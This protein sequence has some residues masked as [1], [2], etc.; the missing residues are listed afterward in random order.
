M[1]QEKIMRLSQAAR[2]LNVGTTTIIAHLV[3]K[4][5]EVEHTPHTKITLDQFN[6]L[7]KEFF[8]AAVD[9]KEASGIT[10]G[11]SYENTLTENEAP[12]LALREEEVTPKHETT[13]PQL[14][15]VLLVNKASP[16]GE[17]QLTKEK[18]ISL[19]QD[20]KQIPTDAIPI[21]EKTAQP[22]ITAMTKK[23]ELE[24]LKGLTV[25]GKINLPE[26]EE[27][28]FLQ[29]AS[30]DIRKSR[31]KRLRKRIT[32][33]KEG[34]KGKVPQ[35]K[36]TKEKESISGKEIQ[37]QIKNTLAKLSGGK[38]RESNRAKYRKEK[39]SAIAE[40][41]EE[42]LLLA[43]EE[44]KILKITEFISANDLAAFMNVP[45]NKVLSTCMSLGMMASINQRLDAEAITVIADEFGYNVEFVDVKN[46]E[47][48]EKEQEDTEELVARAPIVTIMGHVDHG[49]TSLLD[50]IRNTQI[51][52]GEAGGITQHIGAYDVMTENGKKIVFLDTPGHEAFTAMRARGANIT[53]LVIVVVA[54][55][56]KVMPQTK[57]AINHAQAAGVPIVIAIN[58][59]DKPQANP[60]K[61]KEELAGLNI[62]VEDWGGKHQSQLISAKTGQGVHE[63]LEKV[64][65]E[66]ELLDLKT[67]PNKK[68]S[69]TV[70]EA[71]LDQGRGYVCTIMVQS[72]ILKVGDIVLVGAY[73]GKVKAMYDYQGNYIKQAFSS[74]P[75]QILGLDGAPQAGDRFKR[76]HSEKEAREVAIKKQQILREQGLRTQTHITLDEAGRRLA[77]GNF[78]EL[79]IVLKG[80]V[81]GSVEALSGSLLSLSTEEIQVKI[82]HKGVGAISESDILLASTATAMVIGFQVRPSANVRKLAEKEGVDICLYAIIYDAIKHVK[83]A[84]QGMLAPSIEEII[85]GSAL[86]K[87][88]FKISKIGTVAGCYVTDGY[89]KKENPIRLIRDSIVVYTGNINQIKHFNNDIKEAKIGAECGISIEKFN[90][91][92]IGD[93]IEGFEKKE[94]KREL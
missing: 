3:E 70:L 52:K 53:D 62:L 46:E 25:L 44:A 55:D 49:K 18:E 85:T 86:V 57:E 77:I 81:S 88:S 24:S 14:P 74:T 73:Y 56:D 37:E 80:D 13:L 30:S 66:A 10:I 48:E 19:G 79:N 39:R 58:K 84:M 72:G 26:P 83:N 36:V 34:V 17:D 94:V 41:K 40:A 71:S 45:V 5:I 12:D 63:L 90:D 87:E 20:A 11:K 76:V 4:G 21:A 64:L 31:K 59:I 23:K 91:I 68:A 43:Q 42:V 67:N 29:V 6:M 60:D 15:E 38:S 69:G 75:I 92:K 47:V 93:V 16:T 65:L 51:T 9:K 27:K 35:N 2:K 1:P 22:V 33:P 78:K 54:A 28:K 8:S 89:L 50:Y 61:L 82:I 32:T 7:A